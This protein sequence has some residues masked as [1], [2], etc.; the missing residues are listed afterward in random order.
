MLTPKYKYTK[1]YVIE[2]VNDNKLLYYF[3]KKNKIY[4]KFVNS[5]LNANTL[6]YNLERTDFDKSPFMSFSWSCSNRLYNNSLNWLQISFQFKKYK[7]SVYEE[8]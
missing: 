2:R 3:L 5:C 6:A 7:A 4:T 8:I 1:K